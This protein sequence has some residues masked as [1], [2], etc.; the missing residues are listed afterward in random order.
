MRA[1][2]GSLVIAIAADVVLRTASL[3][4]VQRSSRCGLEALDMEAR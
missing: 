2:A 1:L 3:G 4:G